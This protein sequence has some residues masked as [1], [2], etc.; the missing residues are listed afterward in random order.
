MLNWSEF[1]QDW[2][3]SFSRAQ[4]RFPNLHESDMPFLKSD[5]RRFE[6]YLADRHHLTLEE[7]RQELDDFLFVEAL[8]READA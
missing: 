3:S 5:R 4:M 6:A 1:T 7:A 2:A 8:A